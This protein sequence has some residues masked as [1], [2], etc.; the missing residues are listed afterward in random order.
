MVLPEILRQICLHSYKSPLAAAWNKSIIISIYN[1]LKS[2][3]QFINMEGIVKNGPML[4][5][6]ALIKNAV[7][8]HG[9]TLIL[10]RAR[11]KDGMEKQADRRLTTDIQ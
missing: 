6:S 1:N 9:N 3:E 5:N 11:K 10:L 7:E 2:Y 4:Q 8:K